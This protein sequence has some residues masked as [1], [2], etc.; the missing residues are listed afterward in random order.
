MEKIKILGFVLGL[1][2]TQRARLLTTLMELKNK[3]ILG[4]DTLNH[5][6]KYASDFSCF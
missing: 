4:S 1:S 2:D 6:V 3:G 5:P